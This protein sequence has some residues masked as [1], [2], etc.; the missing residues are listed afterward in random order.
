MNI[1]H[2]IIHTHSVDETISLAQEISFQINEPCVFSLVGDLGVGKTHF[3][4]GFA[5]GLGIPDAMR[6]LTSPTFN[7][8]QSYFQ[9][10]IPLFHWDWY[11]LSSVDQIIEL[12]YYEYL[13]DGVYLVEWADKFKT[14][15]PENSIKIC[16]DYGETMNQRLIQINP[17]NVS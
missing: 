1:L 13:N 10:R 14:L 17:S 3:A 9:G 4:K 12:G 2:Q 5:L 6:E 15:I 16:L 11:R 7:L 8:M